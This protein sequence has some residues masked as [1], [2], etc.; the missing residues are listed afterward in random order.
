MVPM[1]SEKMSVRTKRKGRARAFENKCI[2]LRLIN[3][4]KGPPVLPELENYPVLIIGKD[5]NPVLVILWNLC[6]PNFGFGPIFGME[7]LIELGVLRKSKTLLALVSAKVPKDEWQPQSAI[8][9]L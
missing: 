2:I 3:V 5:V 8:K 7:I 1:T 9:P 6:W 4:V